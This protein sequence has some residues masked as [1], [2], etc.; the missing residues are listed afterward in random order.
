MTPTDEG[1]A[2]QWA[3][4]ALTRRMHTVREIE[5]G[6]SRRGWSPETIQGVLDSL[7]A[8]GYLDDAKFAEVWVTTRSERRLHGPLRLLADLRARGVEDEAAEAAV[9]NHLPPSKEVELARRAAARK[10]ATLRETGIRATAALHRHLRSRG[11]SP[12]AIREALAGIRFEEEE[13]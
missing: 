1:T 9:R 10:K 7:G 8:L 5:K 2:K 6:L 4:K 3:I 13:N 11:F 12:D